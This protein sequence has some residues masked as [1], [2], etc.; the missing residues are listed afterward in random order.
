M[1]SVLSRRFLF[2]PPPGLHPT[3]FSRKHQTSTEFQAVQYSLYSQLLLSVL[4]YFT[5]ILSAQGEGLCVL[6]ALYAPKAPP[7]SDT[8]M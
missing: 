5:A 1:R 2:S 4:N 3:V 6:Y 8:A 7:P